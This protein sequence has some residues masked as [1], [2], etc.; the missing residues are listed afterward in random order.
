GGGSTLLSH[1]IRAELTMNDK[2][3]II[4]GFDSSWMY[5]NTN[6]GL[7]K[8][9]AEGMQFGGNQTVRVASKNEWADAK[10]WDTSFAN[11]TDVGVGTYFVWKNQLWKTVSAWVP[12][13]SESDTWAWTLVSSTSPTPQYT[14][15]FT[16]A[17]Q[18]EIQDF[19]DAERDKLRANTKVF[20]YMPSWGLYVGH[21]YFDID[22][23]IDYDTVT[24]VTYSFVK[25]VNT[26]TD[27]PSVQFDDPDVALNVGGNWNAGGDVLNRVKHNLSKYK[28]KYFVFSV[29]GWTYSE[30]HEFEDA[31]STPARI[32]KF[33][34]SLVDLMVKYGFDGIDIDWE[35]PTTPQAAQQFLDLHKT[36]RA[37]LTNLSMDTEKYYQL[38]CAT[39]PRISN[40]QYIKPSE[41]VQYVDTVNYMAYDY[42]GGSFG[43]DTVANHNA[44]L[45]KP[46][47]TT[48][49]AEDGMWIDAV[50]KEYIRQGVPSNQLMMGVP[51]YSRSWIGV[52]N[53]TTG[54][55]LGLPALGS[56]GDRLPDGGAE[57]NDG[58][59]FVSNT[60]GGMWGNGSNPYYRMEDLLAGTPTNGT[61]NVD[62]FAKDYKRYWDDGAK[63][64]Y[65]YSETDKIFHSYDDAESI[66][67]KV[68]YIKD[69]KLA[70]AIVWDLSGDTRK[71]NSTGDSGGKGM[72]LGGIVGQLVGEKKELDA[73]I[74]NSS[75]P[76]GKINVA[77][78]AKIEANGAGPFEFALGAGNPSWLSIDSI[79]GILSG[80]P[81][82]AGIDIPIAL[83]VKG[84]TGVWGER[85]LSLNI[86]DENQEFD[87]SIR[88][89]SLPNGKKNVA[90]SVTIE[91]NGTGSFEFALGTGNPS[92]L[93]I[94]ASTGI[95]SG[96]PTEVGANIPIALKVKGKT[97]VW[98]DEKILSLTIVDEDEDLD[99]VVIMTRLP[100]AKVG[101]QY[102]IKIE[103]SGDGPITFSIIGN[104]E[105]LSLNNSGELSGIPKQVGVL[106]FTIKVVGKTGVADSKEFELNV[107]DNDGAAPKPDDD[108]GG[109]PWLW[110]LIAVGVALVVVGGVIAFVVIKK[111]NNSSRNTPSRGGSYRR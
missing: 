16:K 30:N 31:T 28:D 55:T 4:V 20:A 36:V 47:V 77:Y 29:G 48:N 102:N 63:V 38:S 24:H 21:E 17:S 39:T 82:V 75:L 105:W 65:L 37:K 53:V 41:L 11:G 57:R 58:G 81:T 72:F 70:G 62:W 42:F 92:W 80:T 89:S 15:E 19:L 5:S 12:N 27:N 46:S 54:N 78:S 103:A 97:G 49:P 9:G 23:D 32:D 26:N 33:A 7:W 13:P 86:I 91:A 68:D 50:I 51:Y 79:T 106:K 107:V 6:D 104:P 100:D 71:G 52:Q 108:K 93:S 67:I 111:N 2:D 60:T 43:L 73:T 87:A 45:Y 35:Y 69:N 18:Q 96:T 90:Y 64:P 3:N 14:F 94:D 22:K 74:K 101:I 110:I 25:P 76:D 61:E 98:S 83:K 44:P 34:Q 85:T 84:K 8:T 95:L 88:T 10:M 1:S 66:G 56:K 59:G 99:A 109:N 40:I